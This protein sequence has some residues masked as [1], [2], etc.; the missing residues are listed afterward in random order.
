[1]QQTEPKAATSAP[2]LAEADFRARLGIAERTFKALR[3]A[4]IVS[5]PLELGP[6]CLRWTEDD[7]ADTVS[8]L[9]RRERAAEPQTLAEGRRR[10][11][12]KLKTEVS[13]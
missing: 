11:I 7:Y 5:A 2:L 12:Q 4:G 8:R 1:M 10:R 9:P 6:R 3:A 13:A